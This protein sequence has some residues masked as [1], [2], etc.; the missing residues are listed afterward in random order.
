MLWLSCF[1]ELSPSISSIT[2]ITHTVN[3]GWWPQQS[4]HQLV[5][6]RSFFVTASSQTSSH[7]G[8]CWRL[9]CWDKDALSHFIFAVLEPLEQCWMTPSHI[10]AC[11]KFLSIRPVLPLE[12]WQRQP[13]S[14]QSGDHLVEGLERSRK[15]MQSCSNLALFIFTTLAICARE[16]SWNQVAAAASSPSLGSRWVKVDRRWLCII[17]V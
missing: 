14:W 9:P 5:G 2:S 11:R 4:D 8:A 16:V 17:F 7:C 13:P 12:T 15:A 6:S 3:Y 10:K 1:T